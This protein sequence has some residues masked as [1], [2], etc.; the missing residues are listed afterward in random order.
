[1]FRLTLRKM[2]R[3]PGLMLCL[4]IGLFIAVSLVSSIPVYTNASLERMLVRD[5][6]IYQQNTGRFPGEFSLKI[7]LDRTVYGE[8][9][10]DVFLYLDNK[11]K[12]EWINQFNLPVLCGTT[13]LSVS[14]LAIGSDS[15]AARRSYA[16]L[17]AVSDFDR[18]T[19][20]VAG[21]LYRGQIVGDAVE[22]VVTSKAMEN[23]NLAMNETYTLQGVTQ[24]QKTLRVTVVGVFTRKSGSNAWVKSDQDFD[25][26]F[27]MDFS[28]FRQ[29]FNN[30]FEWVDTAEWNYSMDY[31]KVKGSGLEAIFSAHES[32]V[33]LL[34]RLSNT[35]LRNGMMQ[36]IE[37]YRERKKQLLAS[38]WILIT[39]VFIM[40]SVYIYMV[41]KMAIDL[42]RNEI[43]VYKSRGGTRRQ[44]IGMYALQGMV[45]GMLA[46][47]LGPPCAYAFCRLLGA[48]GGFLEFVGRKA[49]PV[50]LSPEAYLYSGIAV[51]IF[52]FTI[53]FPVVSA[54]RVDIVEHKKALV[55]PDRPLWKKAF[56]ALVC[57]A[58]AA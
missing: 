8:T 5:L 11:V 19:E 35:E 57:L 25:A 38:L 53:L 45:L 27:V 15:D 22:V 55:S 2:I 47:I 51:L 12:N 29:L 42:E 43:A 46:L 9:G 26:G 18:Y 49:L 34:N 31:G 48:S 24:G 36:T 58:L 32:H 28:L 30:Q 44:I 1:M 7:G 21:R 41:S 54:S 10:R 37:E 6:E 40:L 17:C 52:F 33:R 13:T 20:I 50:E 14:H 16:R 39:P 23:L 3:K 56:P 4:F